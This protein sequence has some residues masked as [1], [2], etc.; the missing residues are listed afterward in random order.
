MT[1][2]VVYHPL[3]GG[4]GETCAL[5]VG[6]VGSV[7]IRYVQL[8]ISLGAQSGLCARALTQVTPV[9]NVCGDV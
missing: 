1:T 3:A 4:A 7:V 6:G 5:I 8:V 9:G 2:L